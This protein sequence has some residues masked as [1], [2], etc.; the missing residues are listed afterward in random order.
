VHLANNVSTHSV[1]N[2]GLVESLN[3]LRLQQNVEYTSASLQMS[4]SSMSSL[5]RFLKQLV[6]SAPV[7]YIVLSSPSTSSLQKNKLTYGRVTKRPIVS[8]V[9]FLLY[10]QAELKADKDR[11]TTEIDN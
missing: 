10:K 8:L 6:K 7:V 9:R 4:T 1:G 5:L 3:S 11:K 2:R